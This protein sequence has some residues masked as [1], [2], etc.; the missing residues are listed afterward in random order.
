MLSE[1]K[2]VLGGPMV[3]QSSKVMLSYDSCP[4]IGTFQL[5]G[6]TILFWAA[7]AP[8]DP[9]MRY[10]YVELTDE[11]IAG[12]PSYFTNMIPDQPLYTDHPLLKNR[13]VLVGCGDEE[14]NLAKTAV[15]EHPGPKIFEQ[16][17]ELFQPPSPL[18]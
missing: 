10:V 14:W 1:D 8:D 11:E 15:I 12:L 16:I 6:R 4:L 2:L 3:P 7:D 18:H 5:E 9:Y 13:R 17:N